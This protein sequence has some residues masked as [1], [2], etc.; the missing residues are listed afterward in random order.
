M[1][2]K[3]S[4]CVCAAVTFSRGHLLNNE[5]TSVYETPCMTFTK[6]CEMCRQCEVESLLC[7][8]SRAGTLTHPSL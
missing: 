6:K 8:L 7:V 1:T 5:T 2:Q 4:F 3:V